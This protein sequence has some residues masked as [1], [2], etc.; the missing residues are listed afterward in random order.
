MSE[1][2]ENPE[3]E[4]GEYGADSISVLKRTGSC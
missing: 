3:A 2:T 4:N 1:E